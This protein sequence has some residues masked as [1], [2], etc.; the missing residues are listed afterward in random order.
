M[1]FKSH[2]G[3]YNQFIIISKINVLKYLHKTDNFLII[4]NYE[5]NSKIWEDY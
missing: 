1:N 2:Q 3:I 5:L 4:E